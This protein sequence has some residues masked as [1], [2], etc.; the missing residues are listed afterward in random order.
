MKNFLF[1]SL[2]VLCT[3]TQK[4]SNPPDQASNNF[5]QQPSVF[6]NFSPQIRDNKMNQNIQGPEMPGMES[7]KHKENMRD[8]R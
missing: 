4:L 8:F 6:P 3:L 5:Y 7:Q 1:I 2:L